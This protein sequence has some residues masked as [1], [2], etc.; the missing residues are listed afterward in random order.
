MLAPLARFDVPA[1]ER[2]I[3]RRTHYQQPDSM[4]W[5]FILRMVIAD[6]VCLFIFGLALM[7]VLAPFA[8]VSRK[9]SPSRVLVIAMAVTGG[10]FQVYFWGLWAAFCSATAARYSAMPGVSHHWLYYIAGFM[11]CSGPLS[12]IQLKDTQSAQSRDEVSEI[13]HYTAFYSWIALVAYIVFCIRP[14]SYTWLYS[15][16]LRSVV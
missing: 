4:F 13:D 9:A 16:A 15:C 14:A 1:I 3:V 8:L 6:F 10:A 11:F 12:Y 7:A 5:H 2:Q